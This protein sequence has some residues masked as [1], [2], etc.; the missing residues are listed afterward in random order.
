MI[1]YSIC[2]GKPSEWFHNFA[3]RQQEEN[4]SLNPYLLVSDSTKRYTSK[5]FDS[6]NQRI[7]ENDFQDI[8]I[9]KSKG[10]GNKIII[11]LDFTNH[12]INSTL[13]DEK[14]AIEILRVEHKNGIGHLPTKGWENLAR[15]IASLIL[16][17]FD[18][19]NN[20][21]IYVNTPLP[22]AFLIGSIVGPMKGIILCEYNRYL[23]KLCRCIDL[24]ANEL[25]LV[26]KK[27]EK[28]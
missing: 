16:K 13:I 18:E 27:H 4:I 26:N 21:E 2:V 8:H 22:L 14:Q 23:N 6:L 3:K 19:N 25:Q 11:V 1:Q 10:D 15:E 9:K 28:E 17:Y 5:G 20:I 12:K 7:K 24:G